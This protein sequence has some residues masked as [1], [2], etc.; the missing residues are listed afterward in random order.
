MYT[1]KYI[2]NKKKGVKNGKQIFVVSWKNEHSYH[3]QSEEDVFSSIYRPQRPGKLEGDGGRGRCYE[4]VNRNSTVEP[5]TSITS[6]QSSDKKT[7]VCKV[8]QSVYLVTFFWKTIKTGVEIVDRSDIIK[9]SSMPFSRS[10]GYTVR[11]LYDIEH[12]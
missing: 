3:I 7:T 5:Q 2:K 10:Q 1:H 6:I 9:S 8:H 11:H 4:T 12:M